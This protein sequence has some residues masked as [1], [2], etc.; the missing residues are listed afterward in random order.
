MINIYINFQ[1]WAWHLNVQSYHRLFKRP[2][3][4]C[5]A[6]KK[7][8]GIRTPYTFPIFFGRDLSTSLAQRLSTA[9]NVAS[10]QVE[11]SRDSSTF[12]STD[13][14]WVIYHQF[15]SIHMVIFN[16]GI[17]MNNMNMIEHATNPTLIH[18]YVCFLKAIITYQTQLLRTFQIPFFCRFALGFALT[19]L[20]GHGTV[21]LRADL[22]QSV[23]SI[24]WISEISSLTV[25]ISWCYDTTII[26]N[27]DWYHHISSTKSVGAFSSLKKWSTYTILRDHH[28]R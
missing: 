11:T 12:P 9:T 3:C 14:K 20:S 5:L 27:T 17:C 2:N 4:R 26:K 18:W 7:S 23:W 28:P 25:D 16:D 19:G 10:S 21:F 6:S 15:I 8:Y 1:S 24:W 22:N 13:W